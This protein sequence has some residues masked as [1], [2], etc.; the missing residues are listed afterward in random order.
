MSVD[1]IQ[2][3]MLL[4]GMSLMMTNEIL[5][6]GMVGGHR[7]SL[8]IETE[9][10]DDRA[11]DLGNNIDIVKTIETDAIVSVVNVTRVNNVAIE[12]GLETGQDAAITV[13]VRETV[14]EVD[15]LVKVD[16]QAAVL[17]GTRRVKER[18]EKRAKSQTLKKRS[19]KNLKN[20]SNDLRD[21]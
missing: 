20:I 7:G 6:K 3:A 16:H 1:H 15:P 19:K 13:I 12:K 17:T 5:G 14:Q 21:Y 10:D 8:R 18:N 9:N 11:V 2:T 4:Q